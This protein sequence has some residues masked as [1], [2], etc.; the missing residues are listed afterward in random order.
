MI[1]RLCTFVYVM[2]IFEMSYFISDLQVKY[3]EKYI[4]T[5][6]TWKSIPDRPELFF[7]KIVNENVS[8]VSAVDTR[9]IPNVGR[10][11]LTSYVIFKLFVY[12]SF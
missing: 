12:V 2:T 5:L 7:N 9:H 10:M 1:V 11:A 3:R 8:N 4:S 6:G